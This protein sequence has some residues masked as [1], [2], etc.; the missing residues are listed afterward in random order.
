MPKWLSP[1]IDYISRWLDFQIR[2]SEQPGCAVA[3]VE[4]GTTIFE[5]AFGHSNLRTGE[6]LTPRH[7]FRVASHSKSVTAAGILKLRE[8][9][10]LG[11][12]DPVGRHVGGLH[13]AIAEATIAQLLAHGAGITRDGAD[14]SHW[15]DLRP[16][17]D[18]AAL[19]AAL[20]EP[21]IIPVNSRYKYSNHA[22]GL[23]G[24]VIEAI[25]AEK[26]STWIKRIIID[27]AGLRETLPD[28]PLAKPDRRER[29]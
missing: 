14:G 1:A 17:D 11:L 7:R 3:L 10:K 24:L 9:R 18:T 28:M 12:G 15:E 5:Q 20:T 26:Y 21:P 27:R 4:K 25:T 23:L 16:F 6:A 2:Q 13:R 29:A 19:R 8:E 22:Y